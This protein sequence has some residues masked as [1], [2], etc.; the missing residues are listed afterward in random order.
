MTRKA[1]HM[2]PVFN[3]TNDNTPVRYVDWAEFCEL[4]ELGTAVRFGRR[5]KSLRLASVTK[6]WVKFGGVMQMRDT[7]GNTAR[8][9]GRTRR[10]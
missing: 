4:I 1:Q 10:K 7:Y 6:V 8:H 2:Y 5:G 3:T 9:F